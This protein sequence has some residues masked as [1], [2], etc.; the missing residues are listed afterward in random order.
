[1]APQTDQTYDPA[2]PAARAREVYA[3]RTAEARAADPAKLAK[4]VRTVVAGAPTM[5]AEQVEQLRALLPPAGTDN[6]VPLER[7]ERDA[8][9]GA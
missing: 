1:M 5:S 2:D 4:A 7:S 6:V 8:S 9:K 3:Q